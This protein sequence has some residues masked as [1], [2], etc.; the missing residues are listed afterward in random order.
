MLV[1]DLILVYV[2]DVKD[3][4]FMYFAIALAC[5]PGWDH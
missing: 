5:S 4:N 2:F 1:S 3:T